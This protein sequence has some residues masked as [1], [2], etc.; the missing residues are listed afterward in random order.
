M[1]SGAS[2]QLVSALRLGVL[3]LD[4]YLDEKILLMIHKLHAEFL[5]SLN[6]SNLSL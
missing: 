2:A 1:L 3:A 6:F 4:C 5:R